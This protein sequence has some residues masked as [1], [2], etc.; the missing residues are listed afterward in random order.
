VGKT[1]ES[2][3]EKALSEYLKRLKPQVHFDFLFAKDNKELLSLT[4][5]STLAICLDE[6]GVLKTS[7]EFSKFLFGKLQEGGSRLTI[8]IGGAEGLPPLLKENYPL[9]SLSPMTL[10]HQ[11]VRLLLIEQIYR[12]FEIAKN[13]P[14]HK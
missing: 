12:A 14:Y 10:T 6:K 8:I 13:S 7:S 4:E 9:L 2:W 3:L 5:N 1:K 11:M